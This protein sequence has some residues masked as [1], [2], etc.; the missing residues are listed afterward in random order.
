LLRR[1]IKEFWSQGDKE[2]ENGLQIGPG[3]DR[4]TANVPLGQQFFIKVLVSPLYTLWKEV[5]PE[6]DIALKLLHKNLEFWTNEAEKEKE[7]KANAD[8]MR[9]KVSTV[10][11][12]VINEDSTSVGEKKSTV[13]EKRR[14]FKPLTEKEKMSQLTI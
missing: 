3:R 12:Q 11:K 9:K 10:T 14:A 2:R 1:V 4:N 13:K 5:V 6:S 8:R 7:R